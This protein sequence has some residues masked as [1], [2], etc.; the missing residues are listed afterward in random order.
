MSTPRTSVKM[1]ALA[2]MPNARVMTTT[3]VNPGDL[4]SWRKAK[5]ISFILKSTE[6]FHSQCHHRID[7]TG[8]ARR[9]PAREYGCREHDRGNAEINSRVSAARF[10]K[11][12][13]EKTRQR[14]RA[15]NADD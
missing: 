10:E 12:A 14:T 3:A 6:L 9:Y 8:A 1:A 4:R 13:L 2:P 15:N 11:H 7:S 5:R